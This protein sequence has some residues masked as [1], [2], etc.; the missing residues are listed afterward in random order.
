MNFNFIF[1]IFVCSRFRCSS[2]RIYRLILYVRYLFVYTAPVH[3]CLLQ[4]VRVVDDRFLFC[5]FVEA[6]RQCRCRQ[7]GNAPRKNITRHRISCVY[8]STF[9]ISLRFLSK[10]SPFFSVI[11]FFFS[12]YHPKPG[13][14]AGPKLHQAPL[15]VSKKRNTC[16]NIIIINNIRQNCVHLSFY[17]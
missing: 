16:D 10:I 9:I 4:V 13:R 3:C 2:E 11:T 5:L 7:L 1:T 12:V 15:N 8:F 14:L 17:E 6:R